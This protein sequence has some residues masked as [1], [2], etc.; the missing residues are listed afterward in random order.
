MLGLST[1]CS[2]SC[3]IDPEVF[4]PTFSKILTNPSYSC[5]STQLRLSAFRPRLCCSSHAHGAT[6]PVSPLLLQASALPG[7]RKPVL[8]AAFHSLQHSLQDLHTPALQNPRL[9]FNFTCLPHSQLTVLTLLTIH[10]ECFM[11]Y[12][13]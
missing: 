10:K 4:L 8:R 11:T 12:V 2:L 9:L 1:S 13:L 3:C 7:R 5:Y 6:Q